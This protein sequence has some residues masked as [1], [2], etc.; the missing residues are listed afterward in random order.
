MTPLFLVGEQHPLEDL[1]PQ[2]LDMSRFL[3]WQMTPV[4]LHSLHTT[5]KL[6]R[7]CF[8]MLLQW[9]VQ[10]LYRCFILTTVNINFSGPAEGGKDSC[11]GDSGGPL[12]TKGA[13]VDTGYSLIGIVSWGYGC[14]APNLYGV[15]AEFSQFLP[16]VAEKFNLTAPGATTGEEPVFLS[17][18]SSI[19]AASPTSAASQTGSTAG[20]TSAGLIKM[21]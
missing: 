1:W 6:D 7:H 10:V 18:S 3:Q 21:V 8:Q 5:N 11:Q 15:Y 19:S 13:G 2:P 14:A 20:T 16:W 9:F 17:S 4:L 12:V